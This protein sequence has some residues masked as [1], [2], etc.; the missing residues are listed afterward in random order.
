MD[1]FPV[2]VLRGI[3]EFLR[4]PI[5]SPRIA[6]DAVWIKNTTHISNWWLPKSPSNREDGI[7]DRGASDNRYPPKRSEVRGTINIINL[8]GTIEIKDTT[9]QY[10]KILPLRLVN[11]FF[12]EICTSF[13]Y[14]E[15]NL[16]H[17]TDMTSEEV[18]GLY[19]KY[20]TV[21]RGSIDI[22]RPD[23]Y[24]SRI[25]RGLRSIGFYSTTVNWPDGGTSPGNSDFNLLQEI[26]T[27]EQAQLI[28]HL[29]LYFSFA[30]D[31]IFEFVR[32][33]FTG[34]QTLAMRD[35][36]GPLAPPIWVAGPDTKE[37]YWA[38]YSNLSTLKL[39]GCNN[40][41]STDVPEFVRHFHSLEHLVL[42]EC[43]N[44][45]GPMAHKRTRGWSDMLEGWW[46]RHKPL[47]SMHIEHLY[48]LEVLAMGTIPVTKLTVVSL[49]YTDFAQVFNQ[50]KEI[51]P[52]LQILH[53]E[54]SFD[55]TI[56]IYGELELEKRA[57]I[58]DALHGWK[59]R[60]IEFIP[61]AVV[62][63]HY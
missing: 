60:E 21:L 61:D 20:V 27:S 39:S 13:V 19:G 16:F 7:T 23:L 15:L 34:L 10:R 17:T 26:A 38:S 9:S 44:N 58:Q 36:F 29:D 57:A 53:L 8:K 49:R 6:E 51:F 3:L 50:D 14:Q 42:S 55:S 37:Q 48:D 63:L 2:E 31:K 28:Q 5:T 62:L 41:P 59:Q 56:S 32:T 54:H 4:P 1:V 18:V 33:R 12:N 52:H 46:N 25:A 24:D 47:K 35:M 40:V 11:R 30:K 45:R 22:K 43:H